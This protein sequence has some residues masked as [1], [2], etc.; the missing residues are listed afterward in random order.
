MGVIL[1]ELR[2]VLTKHIQDR[3][4]VA[5][6]DPDRHYESVLSQIQIS[7]CQMLVYDGSYYALRAAAEPLIRGPEPSRVLLYLPVEY[8]DAHL[9]LSELLTLGET[10]RPGVM[11]QGNT[12]LA[13]IARRA[14]KGRVAETRLVRLD[15]EIEENRLTLADLESLNRD[16]SDI[17]L[18]TVLTVLFGTPVAEEAALDFLAHSGRDAE[19][20]SK[21]AVADWAQILKTHFGVAATDQQSPADV[22]VTLARQVLAADLLE[23]LGDGT[24]AALKSVLTSR[25][26]AVW[27]RCAYLAREWRNRRDLALSYRQLA[28]TVEKALHLESIEFSEELLQRVVTFVGLERR[29]LRS[30]ASRLA[31]KE[32]AALAQ[33]AE[34]RRAGFWAEQEPDLQAEW[35]LVAQAAHLMRRASDIESALKRPLTAAELITAYTRDSDGWCDVD[36][37]HRRLEKRASSLEFAMADPPA[38]IEQLVARARHCYSQIASSL[39]EVF[40]RAWKAAGFGVSGFYRQSQI[41]ET[42]VAP[43]CREHRTAYILVDALR[44]EL[45]RELPALLGKEFDVRLEC[46]VGTAPSITEVGMAALLP[47]AAS[48]LRLSAAPKLQV[49]IHDEV[50][51]NRQ[52]RM[53]YLRNNAGVPFAELKLEEPANFKRKLRELSAGPALVVVTSREIDQSGEDQMTNTRE[54]MEKVLSHLCLALRR[55][56][57]NGVERFVIA[58]DHGYVFGED[59]AESEKIDPPAQNGALLHRRV[60]VGRG[61]RANDSYLYT[62]LEKLGVSS[63]LEIAVPWNLAGFRTAGPTAYFHGG[64]SPQEILLPVLT[65]TPTA[66]TGTQSAR[67]LLWELALGSPKI[68]TRFMSVRVTGQSQG[69]FET[70]W[71]RVKVEV[72]AAGEPCSMPVSGTYGYLEATGDVEMRSSGTDPKTTESNT[73][74]LMLTGKVPNTGKVTV[75]LLDAA[76]GVELKRI[77]NVEVSIAI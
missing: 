45:A 51:R 31:G 49:T 39:A 20:N 59:L 23:T 44:F 27:R 55:L 74:T 41:F 40:L 6:F 58:A 11:G 76:T 25:D 33:I 56:A 37:F 7:G 68:T 43:L 4:L 75:H 16:G 5:W 1:D 54:H 53:D 36:T 62:T 77:E 14:L 69:L 61:G 21:S 72:R 48:G 3:G 67:K 57:E 46:V 17:A 73:V 47:G 32:D 64:L 34:G 8:D 24:P 18:P 22:R 42:V 71:P 13:V 2:Q 12:K 26:S 9:P 10:L 15:R 52:D 28:L 38:E 30:V 63:D 60:W 50:L 19:L 29:L 70:D 66:W 35:T 65:L